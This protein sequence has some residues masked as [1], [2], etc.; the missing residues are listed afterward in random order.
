[1]RFVKPRIYT[2]QQYLEK[3]FNSLFEILRMA[4]W[5]AARRARARLSILF[6]RF[7]LGSGKPEP[8]HHHNFQF[9]FWDSGELFAARTLLR[10]YTFQFSFWD[11]P[12]WPRRSYAGILRLSILFLRFENVERIVKRFFEDKCIFQFSFWDSAKVARRIE[13]DYLVELSILFLRFHRRL[14]GESE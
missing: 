10:H 11:S 13:K 2:Y 3:T 6:L 8:E 12:L 9:S 4:P 14:R 1:L 5:N 7:T